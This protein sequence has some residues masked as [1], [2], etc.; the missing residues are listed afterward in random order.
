M[1]WAAAFRCGSP[2]MAGPSGW[3]VLL[4]TSRC[5]MGKLSGRDTVVVSVSVVYAAYKVRSKQASWMSAEP[6][7]ME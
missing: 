4:N 2:W 5:E 7:W 1:D 3:Y 6:S